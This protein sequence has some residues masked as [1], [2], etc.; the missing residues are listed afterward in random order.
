MEHNKSEIGKMIIHLMDNDNTVNTFPLERHDDGEFII[1]KFQD[2]QFEL[3]IITDKEIRTI[4]KIKKSDTIVESEDDI[5]HKFSDL[6][7][8]TKMSQL[9][10]MED[11]F[12]DAD[13]EEGNEVVK[14][15]PYNPKLIR[16][17]TK[18]FSIGQMNDLI[19][20][21]D[22][23][24]SPDFQRGFVWNDITKKSRLIESL[25]LR[26]PIPVFYFAQDEDG[27][28]QVVDGVQRLTVINSF[29]N[30]EFKLKNL[31]YLS[32]CN[33]KYFKKQGAKFDSLEDMYVRRIE[34]TQLFVNVIDPQT[35]GKVKYD[36][37]KRI[38]TG[39]KV[40]NN[41][42]IRN[43]LA[44]S[45]TRNLLHELSTSKDFLRATRKSISAARM[46]DDELVL[47]F[48]AFYLIDHKIVINEYKGVMNELLDETVEI[49]NGLE[50]N[51]FK[52]IRQRFF[53]A[54][55]NAFYLFGD[56][57]FR[58]ANFINKA[59]FL[60]IS[61]VL[62]DIVP[63]KL[64]EKDK[65]E[66]ERKMQREIKDNEKFRNALS[67]ATNDVRNVNLVYDTVKKIIGE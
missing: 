66:I 49:L 1:W 40:L 59:L 41:Q 16:V 44:N 42:E 29:M 43:C 53:Q 2:E 28:F 15:N 55:N 19:E 52:E 31:E 39:G 54:M 34:Q 47:R 62:C 32:E 37:F 30:N 48:I 63:Q 35:P 11:G 45:R 25:L 5:L 38:N 51:R 21:G 12:D 60:G 17:D 22:V 58:K 36:I 10:N 26:I 57:T 65:D 64:Y 23:D 67:M 4:Q 33:G 14:Y 13:E 3:E 20:R 24:L 50:L 6:V 18:T 9:I 46:A 7:F 56:N 61:R 27:L 8:E